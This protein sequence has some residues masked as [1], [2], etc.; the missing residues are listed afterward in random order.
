LRR[1]GKRKPGEGESQA[2]EKETE[3]QRRAAD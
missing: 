2:D 3:P 1:R